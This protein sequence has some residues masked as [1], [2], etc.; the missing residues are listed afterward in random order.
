MKYSH[1]ELIG[2]HIKKTAGRSFKAV[3]QK[4]YPG[5]YLRINIRPKEK[6]RREA[7]AEKLTKI[8]PETRVI[9]GHFHYRDMQ[10]AFYNHNN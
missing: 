8:T 7:F 2:I 9:H 6:N 3:L 10:V 1:L 4:Q 5:G